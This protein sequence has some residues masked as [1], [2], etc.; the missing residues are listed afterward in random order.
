[1]KNESKKRDARSY[2]H[3]CRLQRHKA[4]NCSRDF[5]KMKYHIN[6]SYR[7][8]LV[9]LLRRRLVKEQIA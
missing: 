5:S 8:L 9:A 4:R 6:K 7:S 3:Q 1:M 2:S